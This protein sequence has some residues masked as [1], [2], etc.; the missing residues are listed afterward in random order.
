[1]DEASFQS[2]VSGE[3]RGLGASVLRG[4]LACA[5]VGYGAAVRCRNAG[6]E[7]GWIRSER[8]PVPV[9]SVG[10]IT[11]GGT[12]KTPFVAWL[13]RWFQEHGRRPAILSRGY[14]SIDGAA[15][16]E[17]LV[18]DRLCPGVPHEQNPRRVVGAA[19]L[20]E[21][22]APDVII[23]DDGF[24]HR[25]LTRDLDI[26]LVDALNPWGYGRLLPRGLLREPMSGLRRAGLIV[27]T[28]VDQAPRESIERSIADVRRAGCVAPV[29]EVAYPADVLV[30][31]DGATQPASSLARCRAL[32]FCG[33]GNP[34]GFERVLTSQGIEV[35]RL[36]SF[37]DHHH[38]GPQDL[39]RIGRE[40]DEFDATAI[41]TTE[42]DLVKIAGTALGARPLWALRISTRVTAGE[43]ELS[44]SLSAC[45]R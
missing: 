6:F 39:E 19:R 17:K 44:R 15:N 32:A 35:A 11:T 8:V 4:L 5:S 37:P 1:M 42:K 18:L 20:I 27:L 40:A 26:V 38:Y 28:R 9:V 3:S 36:V 41:V 23:L 13:V 7:H 16:D 43:N 22:H 14:R 31:N 10:N 29:A 21:Q 33:I 30:N 34:G 45:L 2:L 25:R 24:Q 12:G